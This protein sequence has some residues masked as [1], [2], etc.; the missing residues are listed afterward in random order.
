M[1]QKDIAKMTGQASGERV[2]AYKLN[3]VKMSGDTGE[4]SLRQILAEK[5]EDGKYPVVELGKELNGVILKKRWR[6][7]RYEESKQSLMSSEYDFKNQDTV[8]LFGSGEKGVAADIK[9]KYKLGTQ[10][11][12]YVYL[13]G[14]KEVVRL[15][16]KASGMGSEGNP[17]G[18]LGLFAY[19]DTYDAA[20]GELFNDYQTVF[21]GTYRLDP[22]N[23]RKNYWAMT[24]A[25]GAAVLDENKPKVLEMVQEVHKKVGGTTFA[26]QYA[27]EAPT[28]NEDYPVEDIN[29][30]DIPF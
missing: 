17:D 18:V 28:G 9:E 11:V 7:Y 19:L 15:I 21:K 10:G 13:P 2:A 20:N 23:P 27:P 25:K 6:L 5:G 14:R 8:V 22:K 26:V 1:D 24:F 12:L 29:P 16:V 30:D 4:F 3:E